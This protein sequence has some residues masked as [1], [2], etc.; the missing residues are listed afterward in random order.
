MH[1]LFT[2][3]IAVMWLNFAGSRQDWRRR[4]R[5]SHRTTRRADVYSVTDPNVISYIT[6]IFERFVTDYI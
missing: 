3:V 2:N 6:F 5:K 4:S 1:H